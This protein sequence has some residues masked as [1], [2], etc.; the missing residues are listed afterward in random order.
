MEQHHPIMSKLKDLG[1][2]TYRQTE[3]QTSSATVHL[4]FLGCVDCNGENGET[5]T[6]R[7]PATHPGEASAAEDG[8]DVD[9]TGNIGSE[10][11]VGDAV[12]GHLNWL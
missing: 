1:G 10:G 4:G 5:D 8:Y 7:A 6:H 2:Q 3:R 11:S 9:E 12:C